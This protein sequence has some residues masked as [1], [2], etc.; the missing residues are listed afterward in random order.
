MRLEPKQRGERY[1]VK[2]YAPIGECIYC[3]KRADLRKEHIVPYGINGNLTLPQASCGDCAVITSAFEGRV[4][5]ALSSARRG[6]GMQSNTAKRDRP[7][8][9]P[10]GITRNGV[11][12]TEH[13]PFEDNLQPVVMPVFDAPGAMSGAQPID[14]IRVK[15]LYV[16]HY[17]NTPEDVGRRLGAEWVSFSM[18]YPAIE[19]ARMIAKIAYSFW[20]ATDGIEV[21]RSA[22]VVNAIL[23][24]DPVVGHWVGTLREDVRVEFSE[25][26]LHTIQIHRRDDMI[27]ATVYLFTMQPTP[28]YVVLLKPSAVFGR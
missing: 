14:G 11:E 15:G 10:L 22:P 21:A 26:G 24:R 8:T 5:A 23:G 13:V 2:S 3:G 6:M 18:Q 7:T 17:N 19:F 9:A 12:T 28:E 27:C 1:P 4:L 20:I 16:A 25:T